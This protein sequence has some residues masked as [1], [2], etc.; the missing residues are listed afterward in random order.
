MANSLKIVRYSIKDEANHQKTILDYPDLINDTI[1]NVMPFNDSSVFVIGEMKN[2][3]NCYTRKKDYVYLIKPDSIAILA[4]HP[5]GII[6]N[7][8]VLE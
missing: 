5:S 7:F 6:R 1:R 4:R 2:I 3:I 8:P